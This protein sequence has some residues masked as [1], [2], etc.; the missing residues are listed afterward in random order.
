MKKLYLLSGPAKLM[1]LRSGC[2]ECKLDLNVVVDMLR[3]YRRKTH[4]FP[5]KWVA[6]IGL[7]T[8]WVKLSATEIVTIS[9][10]D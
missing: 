1:D 3:F 7:W 4:R 6:S 2:L 9:K 8:L 5:S 10:S